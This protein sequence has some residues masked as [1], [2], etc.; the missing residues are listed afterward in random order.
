MPDRRS[1]IKM[2]SA[3]L[4]TVGAGLRSFAQQAGSAVTSFVQ[5]SAPGAETIY[6]G[7]R[8]LYFGGTGYHGLHNHPELIKAAQ[9]ALTQFG[10][11]SGTSRYPYGTTSLYMDVEKKA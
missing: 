2:A 9:E 5:G 11:H 4:L 3:A 1:F 6:N 8:C 10:T 7:K